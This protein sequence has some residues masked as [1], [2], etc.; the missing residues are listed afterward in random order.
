ML[1]FHE[2]DNGAELQYRNDL[3]GVS[4]DSDLSLPD[5]FPGIGWNDPTL[6]LPP[7]NMINPDIRILNDYSAPIKVYFYCHDGSLNTDS[8][9]HQ[10]GADVVAECDNAG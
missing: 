5:T 1:V 10:N 7:L 4:V 8:I 9:R 3:I 2:G 6:T